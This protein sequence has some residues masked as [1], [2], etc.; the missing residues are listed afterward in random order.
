[1]SSTLPAAGPQHSVCAPLPCPDSWRCVIAAIQRCVWGWGSAVEQAAYSIGRFKVAQG[2]ARVTE[3]AFSTI[4]HL[5]EGDPT[6]DHG[7]GRAALTGTHWGKMVAE[8]CVWGGGWCC[9]QHSR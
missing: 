9:A 2:P 3:A 4:G 5:V 7:M 1:M 8:D 6:G